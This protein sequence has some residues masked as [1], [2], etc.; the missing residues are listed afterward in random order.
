MARGRGAT[1]TNATTVLEEGKDTIIMTETV[2]P[3]TMK[4]KAGT[5]ISMYTSR[6]SLP[7]TAVKNHTTRR[8]YY[9][10]KDGG[11]GIY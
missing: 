6:G 8:E 5:M 9:E 1:A 2:T 10:K 11:D 3:T 4:G 7:R